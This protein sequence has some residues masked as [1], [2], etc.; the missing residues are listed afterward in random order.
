MVAL[1]MAGGRSGM[2]GRSNGGMDVV[3][4]ETINNPKEV[5]HG[6]GKEEGQ[7]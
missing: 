4:E 7:I 5:P 2:S 3:K 6:T 1:P